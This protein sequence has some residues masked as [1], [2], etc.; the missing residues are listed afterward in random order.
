M[1]VD[2]SISNP[3]CNVDLWLVY[4]TTNSKIYQCVDNVLNTHEIQQKKN[5]VRTSCCGRRRRTWQHSLNGHQQTG[6]WRRT[7]HS[8]NVI[9]E[10]AWRNGRSSHCGAFPRR[11]G[12][13]AG[14]ALHWDRCTLVHSPARSWKSLWILEYVFQISFVWQCLLSCWPAF[15]AIP[16]TPPLRRRFWGSRSP[17]ENIAMSKLKRPRLRRSWFVRGCQ[18]LFW[19]L[20]HINLTKKLKKF[21]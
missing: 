5:P 9:L 3:L 13:P 17:S 14:F 11:G 21:V 2:L 18:K 8:S 10:W 19:L 15:P 4:M 6:N 20:C 7:V 16:A 1:G 12:I